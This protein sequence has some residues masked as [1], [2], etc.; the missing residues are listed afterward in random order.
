MS[1][2]TKEAG[3]WDRIGGLIIGLNPAIKPPCIFDELARGAVSIGIGYNRD[4]GGKNNAS[5]SYA[6]TLTKATLEV[7]G[8]TLVEKGRLKKELTAT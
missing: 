1:N 2:L 5:A 8:E 3:E 7:N 4:I 6:A